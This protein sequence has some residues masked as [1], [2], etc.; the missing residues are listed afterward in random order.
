VTSGDF[1]LLSRDVMAFTLRASM[2]RRMQ[3][4]VDD[5]VSTPRECPPAAREVSL[6]GWRAG[7]GLRRRRTRRRPARWCPR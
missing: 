5:R 4:E 6:F 2:L 1:R 3:R 7:G